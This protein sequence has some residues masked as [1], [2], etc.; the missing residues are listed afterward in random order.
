MQNDSILWSWNVLYVLCRSLRSNGSDR[1]PPSYLVA[2]ALRNSLLRVKKVLLEKRLMGKTN[3]Q[4]ETHT[5]AAFHTD[6]DSRM[7]NRGNLS[8]P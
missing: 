3:T 4:T 5:N 6:K 8:F 2:A 1:S 7:M